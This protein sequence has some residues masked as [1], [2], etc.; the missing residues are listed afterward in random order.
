MTQKRVGTRNNMEFYF[1]LKLWYVFIWFGYRWPPSWRSMIIWF[2]APVDLDLVS[3]SPCWTTNSGDNDL[4]LRLG[5][6]FDWHGARSSWHQPDL[7]RS[8]HLV[9]AR[10]TK[11]R[12]PTTN[13]H[14]TTHT[15][16][17]ARAPSPTHQRNHRQSTNQPTACKSTVFQPTQPH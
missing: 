15:L 9:W 2:A 7:A 13:K 11:Q 16:G 5:F 10:S 12:Q 8:G 6:G 4:L 3:E 17:Q 1:S 14:R